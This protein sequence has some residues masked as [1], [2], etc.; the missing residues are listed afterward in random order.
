MFK[1]DAMPSGEDFRWYVKRLKVM[2]PFEIVSR[3]AEQC[4]LKAMEVKYK[5]R[6]AHA[7]PFRYDIHRFGFCTGSEPRLPE[8]PW[9][10]PQDDSTIQDLL[11]GSCKALGYPWTWRPDPSV[12]H[13]APDTGKRWPQIFFGSIPYRNGNPYGD[14]RVAW[15]PS[16]LQ[17][18]VLLGL[19]AGKND[20]ALGER[21]AVRLE[22]QLLSWVEANPT[23]QGIHYIS[24]MECA[25]RILAVCYAVD[26]ARKKL[27][28]SSRIWKAVLVLVNG[29]ADFINRRLS[30]YSSAGNHTIAESA[31]LVYAGTLFPELDGAE[32]W[33]NLGLAQ[34]DREAS[35]QI[36]LDGGGSEQ[37]FGYLQF[38]VDLYGLVVALMDHHHD[39]VP[40][41]VRYAHTRGRQFLNAFGNSPEECPSIGDSD[42]GYALSPFLRLSRDDSPARQALLTFEDSG[43]SM[44]RDGNNGEITLIFD[45]GPL[46]MAPSYGHGHADALSVF[47]R[48]GREE[49]LIDSG[50]YTYA[51]DPRWRSYFRGTPAHNTV[52]VDGSD[53]AVQETPFMWSRPFQTRIIRREEAWDG[54][55][56]LL[57]YHDGYTRLKP[58]VEHW[59]AVIYRPP[60]LWL[61]FDRLAGEGLHT[62]DL[63]WHCGVSPVRNGEAFLLRARDRDFNLVVQGGELS[64][65][66][67]EESPILGWRSRRYGFKE[68]VTMLRARYHGK[69]PHRFV[70]QIRTGD[71]ATKISDTECSG[72]QG[73]MDEAQANRA[74]RCAAGLC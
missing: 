43:Y 59:R 68:P 13:E 6:P 36:A 28:G 57:A 29:H 58:G 37:A 49:I 21:A 20:G 2:S 42:T 35:R 22:E 39:P 60:G 62:L 46:G 41:A 34:L 47:F 65:H 53:Q 50:T 16:R 8:L 17:Q 48:A 15:E 10:F 70:T 56:R 4:S 25:L 71:G 12:W 1:S 5:M 54:E 7:H 11:A 66:S 45:H 63:H 72:I 40:P 52:T 73:W 33:K 67:G 30:L 55:I 51:G 64:L 19:L 74:A 23:Q 32:G 24:A 18:L 44:I 38:I 27:A 61:I 3:I 69:L 26:L 9:S 31:G 14:V